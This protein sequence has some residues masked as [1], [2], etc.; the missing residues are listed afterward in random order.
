MIST[1]SPSQALEHGAKFVAGIA[2][3]AKVCAATDKG[4]RLKRAPR[5]RAKAPIRIGPLGSING[6]GLVEKLGTSETNR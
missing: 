5:S 6:H 1:L 4:N 2:A 3:V